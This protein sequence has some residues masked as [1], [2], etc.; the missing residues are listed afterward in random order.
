MKRALLLLWVV[1]LPTAVCAQV[2]WKT[3]LQAA[4]QAAAVSGKPILLMFHASWCGPCREMEET[5]FHDAAVTKLLQ[6]MVCVKLDVDHDE[7]TAKAY[8]VNSIPRVL[9]LPSA[10]GTPVMDTIG[11]QDAEQF[12]DGLREALHLKPSASPAGTGES[13]ELTEVR[14]ALGSH[15]FAQLQHTNPKLA[16]TGLRQLVTQLGAFQ[17]H[18]IDPTVALLRGAGDSAIPTLFAGMA[19]RYLAVRTGAYRAL[20]TLLRERHIAAPLQYDP[21]ASASARQHELAQ[22]SKWWQNRK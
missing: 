20:L 8:D 6:G 22:W 14:R 13:Q 1:L 7:T 5:T 16:A 12:A 10:G 18:E 4:K 3:S 15:T 11:Y 21:W 2:T 9:L 19:D 17:E